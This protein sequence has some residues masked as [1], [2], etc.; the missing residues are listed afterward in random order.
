MFLDKMCFEYNDDLYNINI[1]R[2]NNK[3][4][5]IRV[6]NNEIYITTNFL[7]SNSSIN[8]LI[9]DNRDAIIKMIERNNKKNDNSFK[10]FGKIY[11]IIYGSLID[12]V[13]ISDNVICARDIKMLNKY[14]NSYVIETYQKH[15]DYWYNIFEEK[16]PVP[17][18]KIRKMTSRW[19][20]CNLKNKNIT[21][22]LDLLKY[23]IVCLDYVIVHEL[24]HFIYPNHSSNFWQLV[25]KYCPNY[26]QIRK[27]LKS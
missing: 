23:D 25:S 3:N 27:K 7:V 10:I 16:I 8:K 13:E 1:V 14:I 21:L 11:T 17:N 6:K 24:S 12:K 19:G 20:V 2:K 22:N 15:L 26:K 18:L 4:T 9:N 5:Y